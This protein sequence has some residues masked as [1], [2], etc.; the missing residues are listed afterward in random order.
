MKKL[1]INLRSE[2]R[3]F[4]AGF[5]CELE[6]T[7]NLII[8]SGVNGTGKSQLGEII[9]GLSSNSSVEFIT[10]SGKAQIDPKNI[11]Y[12]NI[13][14]TINNAQNIRNLLSSDNY[15]GSQFVNPDSQI[16]IHQKIRTQA[17]YR[18]GK[19]S[20]DEYSYRICK[21]IMENT[22]KTWDQ[23]SVISDDEIDNQLKALNLNDLSSLFA[24]TL[25]NIFKNYAVD[26]DNKLYN[27][28]LNNLWLNSVS[29]EGVVE[30]YRNKFGFDKMEPWKFL[31]QALLEFNLDYEFIEPKVIKKTDNIDS[32]KIKNKTNDFIAENDFNFLSSG[33]KTILSLLFSL[34]NTKGI[35]PQVIVLDE[36]DAT[37]NPSL[38]E[39]FYKIL[40]KYFISKDVLVIIITHSVATISMAPDYAS[41]YEVFK[42]NPRI[43]KVEKDKYSDM[44]KALIKYY[45]TEENLRKLVTDLNV[46]IQESDKKFILLVEGESDKIILE[47][48]WKV[49]Y[50]KQEKQF[51]IQNSYSA[52]CINRELGN[53]HLFNRNASLTF[54][55][56]FDFDAEG[57]NRWNGLTQGWKKFENNIF[58]KKHETYKGFAFLLPVPDCRKDCASEELKNT[59]EMPIEFLFEDEKIT[60]YC[61]DKL[62]AQTK[63]KT[64]SFKKDKKVEF[65][66]ST[67]CF[68]KEDF[69]NF[70]P[71]FDLIKKIISNSKEG[72][73]T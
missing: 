54:I 30:E 28:W 66:K 63:V 46:Q 9:S 48:A 37:L 11:V 52:G 26:L 14:G 17:M 8:I 16:S 15:L 35:K 69:K 56:M 50:E 60:K 5:E 3:S 29:K 62:V 42:E 25:Q 39:E 64:K 34:M 36:Y 47:N 31:N 7:N 61:C 20:D 21:A 33:E 49:L 67:E 23:M 68:T 51:G 19:M 70:I 1:S 59:S 6:A 24:N 10:A 53:E 27:L 72:D 43:V 40:E 44:Q 73:Q 57:Y 65:A 38:T 41:F 45:E 58:F 4:K 12:E 18:G 22:S 2:Y 55:G 13:N 71:I 32:I